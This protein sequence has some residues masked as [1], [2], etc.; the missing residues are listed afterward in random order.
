MQE[1]KEEGRSEGEEEL[2]SGVELETSTDIVAGGAGG[3]PGGAV[4]SGEGL[5]LKEEAEAVPMQECAVVEEAEGPPP[6]PPL[7][8]THTPL[9]PLPHLLSAMSAVKCHAVSHSVNTTPSN[10]FLVG[11]QGL[12]EVI[13][14]QIWVLIPKL[15]GMGEAIIPQIWVLVPKL[16]GIKHRQQGRGIDERAECC[17]DRAVGGAGGRALGGSCQEAA[18]AVRGRPAE[19]GER[20]LQH[21]R[22]G[23]G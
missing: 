23:E 8:R 14:P 9:P 21:L 3:P 22:G 5:P 17:N 10:T 2:E 18:F 20:F 11:P 7:Q 6:L 12:S 13:I 19:G 15:S 16:S 4:E 1:V